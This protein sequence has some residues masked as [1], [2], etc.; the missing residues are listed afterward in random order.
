MSPGQLQEE[1]LRRTL[2]EDL[3]ELTRLPGRGG[4][5]EET[6]IGFQQLGV[7]F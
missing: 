1:P 6:L 7:F 3:Q 4:G 5:A 2:R